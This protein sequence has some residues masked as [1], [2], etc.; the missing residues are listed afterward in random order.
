MS[1]VAIAKIG[2]VALLSMLAEA[3]P[4]TVSKQ[5][6]RQVATLLTAR[7]AH[8]ATTLRSGHVLIAGGMAGAEGSLASAELFDPGDNRIEQFVSLVERRA[9]HTATLLTDGRVLIAGGFS[10][11]DYLRSIEVFDPSTKRFRRAGSLITAR[12]GHTATLLSDG[13]V[14]LAGGVGPGWTFL[15]SAELYDPKTGRSEAVGAMSVPRESHT[16]TLLNDG[17]VVM[18][19]GH[20]RRRPYVEVHTSA[21]TFSPRTRSFATTGALAT[22]RHKH[23]AIRLADGRVLVVG[24]ADRSDRVHYATTEIYDPNAASFIPGPS[25]SSKRYK[26]AGTSVLLPNGEVLIASGARAAELLAADASAFREVAGGFPG[27]Y[28]FAASALLH[29]GDVVITGGYSDDNTNTAGVWR[30][31]RR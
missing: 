15:R 14:L 20:N 4:I 30:F 17:R 16:A 6:I 9:G 26:I 8:T 12:S 22:P 13:R 19:G 27:A 5:A 23:D 28:R 11:G 7:S 2:A 1:T 25:M 3:A 18:V 10:G 29:N 31:S 21:E 24:G